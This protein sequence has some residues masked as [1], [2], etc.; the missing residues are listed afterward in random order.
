MM[1]RNLYI[2]CDIR[3]LQKKIP[4]LLVLTGLICISTAHA[5]SIATVT[6]LKL[7]V[8]LQR[9]NS[10]TELDRNSVLK[11]GDNIAT[12]NTGRVELRLWVNATLQLNSNS[13]ITIRGGSETGKA[14]PGRLPELV[15]HRGRACINYTAQ[16]SGENKFIVNVGNAM[17]VAIHLRGDICVLRDDGLSAIKLR[18]GSVQVT[19]AIDPN[20]VIL[21]ETGTEFHIEDAG[22]YELLFPGGDESSTL[23]IEKPF[24]VETVT[25]ESASG[26]SVDVIDGNNTGTEELTATEPETSSPD[27]ESADVYTVYLFSS[28]SEEGAEQVNQKFR[29]AGYNTQIY[30]SVA[31]LEPRYRVAVSGFKSKQ[32]AQNFSD[33]IVG[34]LGVTGTWIGQ[35]GR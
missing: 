23:E 21:S 19:H 29:K 14:N 20:T 16:S 33:S 25:K 15:I 9:D 4:I 13:E 30:K 34:K 5:S 7:P 31:G 10:S 2:N 3:R 17:F 11:I 27:T 28:R 8:W 6:T 26:D 12:G 35:G 24:A 32:A 22:S 18:A 1:I